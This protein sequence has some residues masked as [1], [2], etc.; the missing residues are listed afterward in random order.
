MLWSHNE[1]MNF[2]ENQSLR[3][4]L[5]ERLSHPVYLR[6]FKNKPYVHGKGL[7]K[8]DEPK[9]VIMNTMTE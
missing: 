9:C 7:D 4:S 6:F 1:L 8:C 3:I 2:C 5:K